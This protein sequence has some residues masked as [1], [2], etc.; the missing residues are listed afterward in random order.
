ME[1][2]AKLLGHPIHQML[3]VFP[4]GLL[5]MG[6]IFDLV[7]FGT[8]EGVFAAVAYW[9]AVGLALRKSVICSGGM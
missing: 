8:D 6:V 1:A 5:A 2:R 3:I 9:T 7:Y 4:L